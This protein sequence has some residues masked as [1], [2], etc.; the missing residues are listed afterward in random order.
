LKRKVIQ[1]LL[2]IAAVIATWFFAKHN[3][4]DYPKKAEEKESVKLP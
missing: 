3:Y 1:A 2:F 4:F